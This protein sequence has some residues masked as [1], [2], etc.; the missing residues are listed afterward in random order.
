VEAED[1][2]HAAFVAL[3]RATATS[4]PPLVLFLDDLQWADPASL[5]L[6]GVLAAADPLTP[7]LIVAAFRP[8]PADHPLAQALDRLAASSE[9]S[10][11]LELNPLDLDELTALC[12]DALACSPG[13]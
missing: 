7:M 1:R 11:I 13:R 4:D 2:L 3:V 10:T 9:A 5:K 12:A 6:L 8:V